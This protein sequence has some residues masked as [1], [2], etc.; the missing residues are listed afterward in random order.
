MKYSVRHLATFAIVVSSLFVAGPATAKVVTF[1][2]AE[3]ASI[4]PLRGSTDK[5]DIT[6]DGLTLTLQ[7][8]NNQ[9]GA[10]SGDTPRLVFATPLCLQGV[11]V[12]AVVADNGFEERSTR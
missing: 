6:V 5:V 8:L 7:A 3:F 11:A 1:G 2:A 12:D 10:A 4:G 9:V